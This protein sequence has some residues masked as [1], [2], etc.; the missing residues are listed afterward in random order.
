MKCRFDDR[1]LAR[2]LRTQGMSFS[3]IRSK[4]PNLSKGTLNGWLKDISLTEKQKNRLFEKMVNAGEVGRL[5]GAFANHEKRIKL[6][7]QIIK[8]SKDESI[9][10]AKDPL[11]VPGIM[12]YWAEGYRSTAQ[13]KVNFTN[14]DP[15]MIVLMMRWF[16]NICGVPEL[17]FRARLQL[18]ILHNK[19]ETEIFWSQITGIPLFNFNKTKSHPLDLIFNSLS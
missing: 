9:T 13:E 11:F 10:K 3:E 5:K 12:L 16:R 14:S 8:I 19:K 7:K 18:M 2:D 17:K 4:I 15:M 1:I 6:T